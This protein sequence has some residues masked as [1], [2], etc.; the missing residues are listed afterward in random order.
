[1]KSLFASIYK[2]ICLFLSFSGILSLLLPAV[3]A[4]AMLLRLNDAAEVK[5]TVEPFAVAICDMDETVMSRSLISQ[6]SRVELFREVRSVSREKLENAGAMDENGVLKNSRAAFEAGGLS[7]CAAVITL[8]YDFFYDA[9]TGDEES[10]YVLVNGEMPLEGALTSALVTSV[11]EILN[12]ERAAWQAAYAFRA[13]GEFDPAELDDYYANAA[14]SII[15]SALGRKSV[16]KNANLQAELAASEKQ[17]FFACAASML[18]LFVPAGIIKTLPDERK[19]GLADRFVSVGGSMPGLVL[20]KFI[21]ALVLCSAGLVPLILILRPEL[22]PVSAAALFAAFI[23][24]FASEL[25]LSALLGGTERFMLA[26]G[27]LTAWSLLFG[28]AIYPRELLP[29]FA[30]NIGEL[31]AVRHLISALNG[32]GAKR[33]LVPLALL[34]AVGFAVYFIVMFSRT[35]SARKGR[36]AYA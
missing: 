36:R 14:E 26:S 21:A 15:D 6:L 13:G 7:D 5:T 33:A 12:G 19:L 35:G 29:A 25:A 10:V 30:K 31:T 11:A 27:L 34:S 28:G 20:S 17:S 18:L 22:T 1:M 16:I 2:D 3:V 9:Y 24:C 32:A 4:G 23:A 8:P